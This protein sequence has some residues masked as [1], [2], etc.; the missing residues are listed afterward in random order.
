MIT[1]PKGIY[2]LNLN[3]MAKPVQFDNER[4]FGDFQVVPT[5]FTF[6]NLDSGFHR[7]ENSYKFLRV[8]SLKIQS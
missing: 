5:I 8:D 2:K 1:N 6:Q 4:E 7:F 3:K